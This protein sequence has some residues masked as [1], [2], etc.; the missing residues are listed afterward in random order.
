LAGNLK[1]KFYIKIFFPAIAVMLVLT[2]C[3][4][5][6]T[7]QEEL[8][9]PKLSPKYSYRDKEPMG[10]YMAYHYIGNLFDNTS[11]IV[12]SKSFSK[13]WYELSQD[14][15]AY[16]VVSKSVF[17]S[18]EDIYYLMNYVSNG[19]TAFIS[20]DYIDEQLMDTLGIS[21]Y[22]DYFAFYDFNEYRLEK[23]D[24]WVS[25]ADKQVSSGK[26]YGF[27][28]LPFEGY[29]YDYDSAATQVIS[30]NETG[31]ANMIAVNHGKGKFIFHAAPAAFT[32]YFLL[33]PGNQEYLENIFSY[34]NPNTNFIYWDN[35]YRIHKGTQNF[36]ISAFFKK[37]ESLYPAFLL[38]LGLLLLYI[39]F[40]GKRRQRFVQEKIPL[41]NSTVSYAET[42][43][44]LYL[45]KRDNRN[46]AQKMITYFLEYARNN[47][48]LNTN[49]LNN[50]FVA[51]LSRKSGVS[52]NNVMNL[53]HLIKEI[54][55]TEKVND[56]KLLELHNNLQL[57]IKK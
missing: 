29:F 49:Q 46:I 25:L 17:L 19:N 55:E 5:N 33:K 43:G 2:A 4:F 52:E 35:Y 22:F 24:T 47:Y 41:A 26:K 11:A 45:Q 51:A 23:K 53:V 12:K 14:K 42:I 38:L 8:K 34:L 7:A 40:G 44:R 20:A 30:H 57:F 15:T 31:K 18:K 1:N 28:W 36:S 48:F 10:S 37:S 27:F 21:M 13:Q 32:N 56:I 39:A 16:L 9:I 3:N 6:Q 50:E 54:N